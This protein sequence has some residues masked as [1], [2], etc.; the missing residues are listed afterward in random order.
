MLYTLKFRP[1]STV[2]M[3]RSSKCNMYMSLQDH[4]S[5]YC[6]F[7]GSSTLILIIVKDRPR[8]VAAWPVLGTRKLRPYPPLSIVIEIEE[9]KNNFI[10]C[11]PKWDRGNWLGEGVV[12][13]RIIQKLLARAES[14]R[15]HLVNKKRNISTWYQFDTTCIEISN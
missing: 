2:E 14:T 12:K 8:T 11:L 6:N 7:K 3:Q 5:G 15:R 1:I 13:L 9:C 10:I 4:Q